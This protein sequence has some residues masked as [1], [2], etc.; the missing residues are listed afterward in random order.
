M[1]GAGSR[2]EVVAV[3]EFVG[4]IFSKGETRRPHSRRQSPLVPSLH[5]SA[6]VLSQHVDMF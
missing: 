2:P 6:W 5:V 4:P 1:E 3:N